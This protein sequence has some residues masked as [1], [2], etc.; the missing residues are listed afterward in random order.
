MIAMLAIFA[1]VANRN[2]ANQKMRGQPSMAALRGSFESIPI[3]AGDLPVSKFKTVE[4]GG[5]WK[6]VRNY[7]TTRPSE[8]IFD[9]YQK[10]LPSRG[11]RLANTRRMAG[12]NAWIKFCKGS[13]SAIINTQESG[14][15][16]IYHIGVGWT[17]H[18]L[19]DAFCPGNRPLVSVEN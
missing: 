14:S 17:S 10:V 3:T 16:T 15:V 18:S 11:W 13:T 12:P 5:V 8:F 19:N 1:Y 2:D 4:R 9:Y 6:I 7:S